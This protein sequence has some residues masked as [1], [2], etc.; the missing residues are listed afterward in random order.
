MIGEIEDVP[1]SQALKNE[2]WRRAMS[3]EIDYDA[4]LEFSKS[5]K[6]STTSNLPL[7]FTSE[8]RRS[9]QGSSCR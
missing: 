4:N 6:A 9:F 8:T 1:I 7:D 5:S 2:K 3:E